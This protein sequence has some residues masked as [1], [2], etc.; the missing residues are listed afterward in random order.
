MEEDCEFFAMDQSTKF[1]RMSKVANKVMRHINFTFVMCSICCSHYSASS[2]SQREMGW[3]LACAGDR[4]VA[5][6][7]VASIAERVNSGRIPLS[8]QSAHSANSEL[9]AYTNVSKL[10]SRERREPGPKSKLV[11]LPEKGPS[12]EL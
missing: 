6:K 3:I 4:N 1:L 2:G 12:R 7:V 11:Q 10:Q 5:A 8:M 9:A